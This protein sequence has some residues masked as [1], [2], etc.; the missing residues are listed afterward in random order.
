M[1]YKSLAAHYSECNWVFYKFQDCEN[2]H[3]YRR[4]LGCCGHI[5]KQMKEC[6]KEQREIQRKENAKV[7]HKILKRESSQQESSN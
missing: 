7:R 2:E 5:H 3:P 1:S 6:I 4:F